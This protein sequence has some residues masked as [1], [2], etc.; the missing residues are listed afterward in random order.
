[1]AMMECFKYRSRYIQLFQHSLNGVYSL[2]EKTK[3]NSHKKP[4]VLMFDVAVDAEFYNCH[5]TSMKR[6]TFIHQTV[7][8]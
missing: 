2:F 8:S 6:S 7:R 4:F 3:A 1:M 5:G